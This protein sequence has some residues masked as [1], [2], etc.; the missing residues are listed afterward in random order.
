[1]TNRG[2][3][4]ERIQKFSGNHIFPVCHCCA[5]HCFSPGEGSEESRYRWF[6]GP[7]SYFTENKAEKG[8]P[9]FSVEHDGT[10]YFLTSARQVELFNASPDKFEPRYK[11]CPY[12]LAYGMVLPLDPTNFKILGGELL[13]FHRSEEKDA[14]L[15]WNFLGVERGRASAS[16]R[17]KP[18][19]ARVLS[20]AIAATQV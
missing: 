9:E 4:N 15:E 12:S 10:T 16:R 13:L 20:N 18:V 6:T 8:K 7:V 1:M 17:C 11:A 5:W 3:I 14:L 19:P 2:D